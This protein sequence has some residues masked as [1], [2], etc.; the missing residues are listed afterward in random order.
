MP[1]QTATERTAL[2]ELHDW[3]ELIFG[4]FYCLHC[5]PDDP[6]SLDDPIAWPCPTLRD[7]GTLTAI[8][9]NQSRRTLGSVPA[10]RE[11]EAA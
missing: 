3:D 7:A 6:D 1:D 8:S 11:G 10:Q 4:G 5:T 2:I 9:R